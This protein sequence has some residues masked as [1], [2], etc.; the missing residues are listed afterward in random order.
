[1]VGAVLG[2]VIIITC[3][4]IAL[5]ILEKE[6]STSPLLLHSVGGLT[7]VGWI[8]ISLTTTMVLP[9]WILTLCIIWA[10]AV[11]TVTDC[12]R[13]TIP[14]RFLLLLLMLWATIIGVYIIF[15]VSS[16]IALLLI[17]LAGALI[18]GMIFFLCYILSRKQLGAGDVK[19]VFILGLFLTG[20]RIM[21]AIF[22]GVILC[23][24]FSCIQLCRKKIG[25]KDGIPLV[26]FLYLGTWITLLIL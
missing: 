10:L 6:S 16:G 18:G 5:H 4:Y 17:S 12:K 7:V 23:C 20:Q 26:P 15:D 11:L 22:Y 1:M 3:Y 21:G 19:L 25:I 14:N 9:I 8:I 24:I 2:A 13:Y